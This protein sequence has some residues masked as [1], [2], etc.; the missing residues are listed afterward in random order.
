MSVHALLSSPIVR[1]LFHKAIIQ[2]GGGRGSRLPARKLREDLPGLPSAESVGVAFAKANGIDGH[3]AKVLAALRALPAD[4]VVNGLNLANMGSQAAT[5]VGGPVLDGK[6]VLETPETAYRNERSAKVP[7]IVG[8]NSAD[9][10]FVSAGAKDEL[11]ATFS[12]RADA[13][14]RA[15]DPDGSL[16]VRAIAAAIGMDQLMTEPARLTA[17]LF[18]AQGLPAYQYRF[19]YVAESMRRTWM[20]GA[21][22]ATEIPYVFNTVAAKYGKDL[23][24]QDAAVARAANTYWVNF[25]RTGNPNGGGLPNW[26]RY[27]AASDEILDFAVAGPAATPDPWKSRLDVIAAAADSA[28]SGASP[29]PTPSESQRL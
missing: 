3:A 6:I 28:S 19:S 18:A 26:P 12:A 17:Q 4:S 23:T 22:H 8:A 10:G 20:A 9:I 27:A 25:A 7:I 2:S 14:R 1:G 15:Y 16:D 24:P 5:Y 21:P 13:V 29:G 11:F